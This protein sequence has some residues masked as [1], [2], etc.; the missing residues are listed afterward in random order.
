MV[1]GLTVA[2]LLALT[3]VL[4]AGG[5]SAAPAGV[6]ELVVDGPIGPSTADYLVRGLEHA[7]SDHAQLVVI[8]IDT[9]GGLDTSMRQI[10]KAILA[11]PVPV[12][13]FVAPAGAR[14]AS[15]GTFI[16]YASHIAAMA[17]GT[18]LGAASPVPIGGVPGDSGPRPPAGKKGEAREAPLDTMGRKTMNDAAAYIRG[19]AQLRGRNVDWAERAVRQ[20]ASVPAT[21]ALKLR[22]ADYV[23]SD[24]ADLLKQLDGKQLI[25]GGE[26]RILHTAG[27]PQIEYAPDWRARLLA[28]IANPSIALVLMMIGIYGLFFEFSNPGFVAPGVIGAIALLLA[29]FGLQMLP[30]N[31]S[32][33]ALIALGL[34]LMVAELFVPSFGSLGIGGVV[35]TA[36]GAVMLVDTDAPGF[37]VPLSLVVTLAVTTAVF[38][39]AVGGMALRARR[40]PVVTGREQLVG[41]EGEVLTVSEGEVWARVHGELWRVASSVPLS[42][43]QRVRVVGID[44][45]ELTVAPEDGRGISSR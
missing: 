25:V 44:G 33:L 23:A 13:T 38:I 24:V 41:S 29:M 6:A 19:L 7:A 3:L 32:G 2:L 4:P 18:N 14:A 8:R 31:Y 16:F 43:G 39:A 22:V 26:P 37:G 21:E 34:A 27:A 1:R 36:I 42:P 45:L 9:P 10:V 17:P 20:A 35:A 11:S 5:L 15:A 30:I 40:R 28:A 12:A